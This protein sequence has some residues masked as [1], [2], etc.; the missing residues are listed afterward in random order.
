MNLISDIERF[1]IY[2]GQTTAGQISPGHLGFPSVGQQFFEQPMM[3][4]PAPEISFIWFLANFFRFFIF[5]FFK[6]LQDMVHNNRCSD[7]S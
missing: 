7:I 1:Y 4:N 3:I 2:C 5:L 6:I